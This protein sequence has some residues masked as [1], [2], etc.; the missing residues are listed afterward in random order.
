M[1]TRFTIY[2]LLALLT[3]GTG[4]LVQNNNQAQ[5]VEYYSDWVEP[6]VFHGFSAYRHVE[7]DTSIA[8]RV[9]TTQ[10]VVYTVEVDSSG[11]ILFTT[12]GTTADTTVGDGDAGATDG[13]IDVSNAAYDTWGEVCDDINDSD[14]WECVLVDVLPSD[15]SNGTLVLTAETSITTGLSATAVTGITRHAVTDDEGIELVVELA[16]VDEITVAI[17]PQA[18]PDDLVDKADLAT[19][20]PFQSNSPKWHCELTSASAEATFSAGTS[21]FEVY[22]VKGNGASAIEYLAYKND[23][24]ATTVVQTET[25]DSSGLDPMRPPAGW[26]I[27]V[28]YDVASTPTATAGWINAQGTVWP[29]GSPFSR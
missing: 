18:F 25:F 11:D 12:D 13:K 9:R 4:L 26:H 15:S 20:L 29:F 3:L 7:T 23:G 16:D 14:N 17:G 10:T 8:M 19:R 24:S 6:R 2:S 27:V 22:W 21:Y 1:K 28:K 5:A